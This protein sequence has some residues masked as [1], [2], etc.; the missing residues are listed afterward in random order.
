M[1]TESTEKVTKKVVRKVGK[2]VAKK[3]AQARAK[4][5]GDQ[6]MEILGTHN[7]RLSAE[8]LLT[9]GGIKPVLKV[10]AND[11]AAQA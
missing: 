9:E 3:E 11:A 1:A 2:R 8:V 4:V 5:A 10:V 6:I 7:C